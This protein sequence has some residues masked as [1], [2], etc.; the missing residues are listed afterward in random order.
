[1]TLWEVL[2]PSPVLQHLP[3]LQETQPPAGTSLCILSGSSTASPFPKQTL[4]FF[5]LALWLT[6]ASPPQSSS[7]PRWTDP[8]AKAVHVPLS[9]QWVLILLPPG[10]RAGPYFLVCGQLKWFI[11]RT[12]SKDGSPSISENTWSQM[13]FME[14]QKRFFAFVR[15]SFFGHICKNIAHQSKLICLP[16]L[17]MFKELAERAT[18]LQFD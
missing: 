11:L 6:S 13:K 12:V 14:G 3:V 18:F 10:S 16:T 4:P 2:D 8:M 15:Q 9:P 5:F 7:L 17:K 1:M